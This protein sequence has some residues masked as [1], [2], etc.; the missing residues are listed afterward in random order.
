MMDFLFITT[1]QGVLEGTE[2]VS[3]GVLSWLGI[4]YAEPPVGSLRFR[5][6]V[7]KTAWSGVKKALSSGPVSLQRA[8]DGSTVGSEDCLYLNVWRPSDAE[9][10]LPV[11]FFLHGGNNQTGSGS[12]LN[13]GLF[14]QKLQAVVVSPTF[15]L[16]APGW[17][18]LYAL[19]TGDPEEDSGNFGLL[20]IRQALLWVKENIGAFGG[21]P[22][23]ITACGYSSGGR[24]L[25]CMLISPLFRG[26][27]VRAMTFSSG[28][29]VTDPEVGMETDAR[30]L[31]KLAV[32]DQLAENEVTACRLLTSKDPDSVIKVKKWLYGINAERF[33]RLM[34]GAAIR[35]RVFPHLFAD[36]H[37]L[38]SGGFQEIERGN[39]FRVP[40][41]FL[42]G[43]NEFVFQANFDPYFKGK[44]LSDDEMLSEY[45]FVA[46]YGSALFGYTNAE[47]NAEGFLKDK[48]H[49]P[50]YTGR[51]LWGMD[52]EV[53]DEK[54]AIQSG[55]SHGLDLYLLMDI[56]REDYART[57]NVWHPKN[58]QGRDA[59][60]EIYFKYLSNYIRTGDPN[61]G[62]YETGSE[63]L[64]RW[65]S[66][67][68]AD[69]GKMMYFDAGLAEARVRCSNETWKEPEIFDSIRSDSSIS[70]ERK[71][72][73]LRNVLNARFFS[74]R[75]DEVFAE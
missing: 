60:R 29:T 14:A 4:P 32:E 21:D 39:Y 43:G 51:C 61:Q 64:P 75:L 57:E 5:A 37:V 50:V 36:G 62:P 25:L 53:T 13:G 26:M 17:L 56:E 18:N 68:K 31:A 27:F 34:A 33:G 11:F 10:P 72:Y 1:K 65:E 54:A 45:R 16:N 67:K 20:D 23:N 48:D 15:R 44:D 46:R 8:K 73:L 12:D 66:W 28:F 63:D 74:E 7:P 2:D 42:S 9:G 30:A 19:K 38:P 55:G 24:N 52:P 22:E 69:Q 35:M 59:L 47:H 6:P 49:P 58:R 41:L 3:S 40:L 70:E 71:Y